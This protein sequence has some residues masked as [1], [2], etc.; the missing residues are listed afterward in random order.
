MARVQTAIRTRLEAALAIDE[1]EIVDESHLHRG[2]AG[3]REEGESHF[4]LRIVSPDF[5]G[6]NRV[7]RQRLV[8]HALEREMKEDIH[9]LTIISLAPG[10]T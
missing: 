5:T 6:L 10:E 2:H 8:F 4:R 7:S 3:A 1:M 9:A